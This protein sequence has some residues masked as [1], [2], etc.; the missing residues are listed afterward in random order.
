M[1]EALLRLIMSGGHHDPASYGCT[2]NKIATSSSSPQV[3]FTSTTA[4]N[5]H[6]S[7]LYSEGSSAIPGVPVDAPLTVKQHFQQQRKQQKKRA[8]ESRREERLQA[9]T[10]LF[11]TTTTASLQSSG[12]TLA[13][14]SIASSDAQQQSEKPPV[15]S[16]SPMLSQ[17]LRR[18]TPTGQ[19]LPSDGRMNVDPN[20]L[21]PLKA[22]SYSQM[23]RTATSG[24]LPFSANSGPFPTRIVNESIFSSSLGAH[25][26]DSYDPIFQMSSI[27]SERRPFDI[28][29]RSEGVRPDCQANSF[30]HTINQ[31]PI[32]SMSD[33]SRTMESGVPP[34]L[35]NI[36]ASVEALDI[37]NVS[38][39]NGLVDMN[40]ALDQNHVDADPTAFEQGVEK[41]ETET[42]DR[43]LNWLYCENEHAEDDN[44]EYTRVLEEIERDACYP[45]KVESD[46][47][48][49][50]FN[51]TAP[52][53]NLPD[54]YRKIEL[55]PS[56]PLSSDCVVGEYAS[57]PPTMPPREPVPDG[58]VMNDYESD[59]DLDML[60]IGEDEETM[61]GRLLDVLVRDIKLL[62]YNNAALVD[63]VSR[64]NYAI[65]IASEERKVLARRSCHHDRNRIRRLQTANKRKSDA[66]KRQQEQLT[67]AETQ[68]NIAQIKAKMAKTIA[69]PQKV[70]PAL[71]SS[72]PR[73]TLDVAAIKRSVEA[74]QRALEVRASSKKSKRKS[75]SSKSQ[76]RRTEQRA[77]SASS[78]L[79][80]LAE[81][82]AKRMRSESERAL[83]S[84][85]MTLRKDDEDPADWQNRR[86]RG[87]RF[88]T[89]Q[90]GLMDGSGALSDTINVQEPGPL[91][92]SDGSVEANMMHEVESALLP[93]DIGKDDDSQSWRR[94]SGRPPARAAS[95][96]AQTL[97]AAE[98]AAN[99]EASF[100]TKKPSRARSNTNESPNA[101]ASKSKR[102]ASV[103]VLGPEDGS[104]EPLA[105][106]D[107]KELGLE[108]YDTECHGESA[109][110]DRSE[111]EHKDDAPDEEAVLSDAL[112]SEDSRGSQR[113]RPMRRSTRTSSRQSF[114]D[115]A[116]GID[117]QQRSSRSPSHEEH[118]VGEEPVSR[119]TRSHGRA[120][121][122]SV[123]QNERQMRERKQTVLYSPVAK[124]SPAPQS[125]SVKRKS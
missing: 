97:L 4:S 43:F 92:T 109:Y 15:D 1:I 35:S 107:N 105:H 79:T 44:A 75:G 124:T 108:L 104:D 84:E 80:D 25:S 71:P 40:G 58:Y 125:R 33:G 13:E 37:P 63:E 110:L 99:D 93:A 121:S 48:A 117:T 47:Q 34:D 115:V 22:D 53:S 76:R 85:D 83:V 14:T 88:S 98:L 49:S 102:N 23:C 82:P 42:D 10:R 77:E 72:C 52:P 16:H 116:D 70:K 2:D 5:G 61:Y 96:A 28:V 26:S 112:E 56:H 95:A 55:D 11:T 106:S 60:P 64:L 24:F 6:M 123:T 54:G 111:S 32:M 78:A 9:G 50:D 103:G 46:N 120:S 45:L 59:L 12:T 94:R 38:S 114:G 86:K 118:S 67:L 89:P 18:S 21:E 51:M 101:R 36:Y 68:E 57:L 20:L 66:Q 31:T 30:D 27:E 74:E 100:S 39:D 81:S 41:L 113:L 119:A 62:T 19:D 17:Q 7:S 29:A 73:P 69:S 3:N 65:L 8:R 90:Q 91:K 122:S 87:S